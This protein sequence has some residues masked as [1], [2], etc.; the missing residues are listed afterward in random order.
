MQIK[1]SLLKNQDE[2]NPDAPAP[3]TITSVFFHYF[4][5]NCSSISG[6]VIVIFAKKLSSFNIAVLGQFH[7]FPTLIQHEYQAY[8]GRTSLN[9]TLCSKA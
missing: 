4:G 6:I 1:P 5:I 3:I 9:L 8:P 2:A 7:T